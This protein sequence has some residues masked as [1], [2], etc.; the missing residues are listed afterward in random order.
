M[1]MAPGSELTTVIRS[2]DGSSLTTHYPQL[3]SKPTHPF[4]NVKILV[5]PP[6]VKS[7]FCGVRRRGF[8][9]RGTTMATIKTLG[10]NSC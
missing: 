10:K 8:L 7:C 5:R 2:M 9:Q 1:D 6:L 4:P 3:G